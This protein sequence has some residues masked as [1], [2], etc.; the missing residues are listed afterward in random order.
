MC[1]PSCINFGKKVLKKEYLSGK[2]VIEVGAY[3]VNGSLRPIIEA[4]KPS[5]YIG[6]DLQTGPG[7][8]QICK[9]EELIKRFGRDR[10][11]ALICTEVLEHVRDW[12]KAVHNLKQIVKPQGMLLITTRSKG[13][14]YH[15]FPY[16][17]WRYEI[18][19]MKKIFSDFDIE[20]LENDSECPGAFLLAKKPKN[21]IENINHQV[22]LFS[23]L[24]GKRVPIFIS[25]MNW[26]IVNLPSKIRKP[27]KLRHKI[28][29]SKLS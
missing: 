20:I 6:V 25:N 7:V 11:D 24:L 4:Y 3:D 14:D 22:N 29:N 8:D 1:H 27:L 12:R 13:F 15:G 17:F 2:S 23:M 16:D 10:F 19:D 18:S 5:S 9:I 28:E 26:F 21:F